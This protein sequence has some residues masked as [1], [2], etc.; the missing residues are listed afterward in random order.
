M[1][2]VWIGFL[3]S[4]EPIDQSVMQQITGFLQQP[5]ID[6]SSV[7]F[8]CGDSGER[9]GMMMMFEAEDRATAEALVR[10]SPVRAAGLY[11]EYHLFEY[12][13]EIG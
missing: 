9:A 6:I 13:N 2:F 8:L 5:Y 10:E 12:R 1:Q 11:R 3:K 7:G 4:A